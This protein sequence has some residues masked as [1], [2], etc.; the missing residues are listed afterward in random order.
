VAKKFRPQPLD[1]RPAD[2]ETRASGPC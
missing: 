1:Q 2:L